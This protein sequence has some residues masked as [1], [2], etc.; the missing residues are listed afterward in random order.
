VLV[1]LLLVGLSQLLNFALMVNRAGVPSHS[2]AH[3]L[4]DMK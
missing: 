2:L 4:G 3:L 1:N